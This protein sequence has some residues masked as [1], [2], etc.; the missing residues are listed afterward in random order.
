MVRA[1]LVRGTYLDPAKGRMT[2]A[3][4]TEEWLA[5]NPTKRATTLARDRSSIAR[6][7]P[8]LAK[9][10]IGEIHPGN[11]KAAVKAMDH[12]AP[13]TVRTHYGVLRAALSWAVEADLL[14][15]SPC[16]GV[17]LPPVS[18][19]GKP[20][21]S[22]E[23]LRRLADEMPEDY[24]A[25]IWLGSLGLRQAEVFGLRVGSIDFLRRRL[26]VQATINE[27]EGRMVCG[28]GKTAS[29]VRTFSLPT[30]VRDL[31]AAHLARTGRT[32]PDD[33]VLQ[34]PGGG[35]VRANNFRGRIYNPALVRA[36][37]PGLTFHRLRHSAGHLMRE[38][39]VPLD[40]IQRRLGHRSI[41]TTADIYG[42]LPE[43]VDRAVADQLD[44]VFGPVSE[45]PTDAVRTDEAADGASGEFT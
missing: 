36:G 24:R 41:R 19:V 25:A 11:I 31:L 42:S 10:P 14:D 6:F 8:A 16:R 21:A 35:P 15:R 29:S 45:A 4:L 30:S 18:P 3:Q 39:G 33:L 32:D 40:V 9:I 27:V 13:R 38:R 23:A 20:R 43:S 1:D 37:L 34:A 12:L 28:E 7:V 26:T 17:N 44:D 5:S 22:A 2:F